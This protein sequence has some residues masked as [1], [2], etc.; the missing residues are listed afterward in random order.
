MNEQSSPDI[1]ERIRDRCPHD[2]GPMPAEA[3]LNEAADEIEELR[4]LLRES[5][6]LAAD[7]FKRAK[8]AEAATPPCPGCDGHDCI[9]DGK[10]DC[11]YPGAAATAGDAALLREMRRFLE[12]DPTSL[13]RKVLLS[14]VES[15]LRTPDV[16]G[17]VQGARTSNRDLA[18]ELR[19]YTAMK[20]AGDCKCGKCQLVPRALVERIYHTLNSTRHDAQAARTLDTGIENDPCPYAQDGCVLEANEIGPCLCANHVRAAGRGDAAQTAPSN[21]PRCEHGNPEG[22]C[23]ICHMWSEVARPH[24][25]TPG[26]DK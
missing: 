6:Q 23:T 26:E 4:G 24:L 18:E 1:V 8:L 11:Q 13:K 22:V 7:N 19:E 21:T 2:D 3:M 20:Y 10:Y 15:A 14:R 17:D 5:N 25:Y 9:R 16:A 12:S